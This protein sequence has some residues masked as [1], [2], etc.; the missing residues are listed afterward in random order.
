MNDVV[1]DP[2]ELKNE[3]KRDYYKIIASNQKV[4]EY[5]FGKYPQLEE[6]Y[7]KKLKMQ[8]GEK[9]YN[10]VWKIKSGQKTGME[11]LLLYPELLEEFEHEL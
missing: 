4:P 5:L 7:K 8:Y 6:A 9:Q 1:Y 2:E 10:I 11:E 3:E